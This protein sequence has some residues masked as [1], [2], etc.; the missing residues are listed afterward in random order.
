MANIYGIAN[1][2]ALPAVYVPANDVSVTAG[3]PATVIT[4]GA[5]AALDGESYYPLVLAV[6]VI[7]LGGSPAT[8][9]TVKFILG[10]GS[11]VDTYTVEPGL[12]TASAELVVPVFLIGAS[13]D[14][15]WAGSGSTLNIQVTATTQNVTVKKVGSRAIVMLNRG[16]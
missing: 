7:V 2:L 13:S 8:A 9:L 6:L 12:L 5:I 4:T 15:A 14:S 1:P 10:A 3:T 16:P 11:A